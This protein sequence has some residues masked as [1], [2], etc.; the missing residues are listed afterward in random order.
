M[1]LAR[2][3]PYAVSLPSEGQTDRKQP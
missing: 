3:N 1:A 2:A